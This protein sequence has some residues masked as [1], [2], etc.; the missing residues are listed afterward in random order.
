MTSEVNADPGASQP[1]VPAAKRGLPRY[2]RR[3][4][5]IYVGS[6]VVVVAAVAAILATVL[7]SGGGPEPGFTITTSQG[8]VAN[9]DSIILS[10]SQLA[11]TIPAKLHFVPFEAGVT[12]VAEL[13]SGSV[14]AISG[15]GNPPAT[16]AIGDNTGITVVLAQSFDADELLVPA[17]VSAPA[18]LAGKSVGVLVGSS[19]DYELRGWLGLNGLTGKV[20]LVE[21]GSEQAVAAAYVAGDIDAAY[22]YGGYASQVQSKGA[23][24]ITD[25]EDIAKEGVP[26]IDVVAVSTSLVKGNPTLVQKYV[27]AEVTATRDL[28]GSDSAKYLALA[29]GIQGVPVSEI[30]P[31]TAA[32]PFIP[33]SQEL[34]WLGSAPD[35]VS[36][37]IVK[38]YVQTGQFLVQQGR[39]TT[40]PTTAA[41]A[42]HVDPTFVKNALSGDC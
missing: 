22:V 35:D 41:V 38:A 1:A 32:Y 37:P 14:Q 26:G 19:E 15:V 27:C 24:A 20:K 40:A 25:A 28:T 17:S 5:R 3:R 10:D 39:L 36:A 33:L 34:Y 21:L 23:H 42:A 13:R 8:T 4:R 2:K 31:A 29:A 7:T 12:A 9:S 11:A 30:G 18:Q 16:E 6:G